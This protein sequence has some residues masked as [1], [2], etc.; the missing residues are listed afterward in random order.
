MAEDSFACSAAAQQWSKP[1]K[2][3]HFVAAQRHQ[4]RAAQN[5]SSS[6]RARGPPPC[7]GRNL[8]LGRDSPSPPGPNSVRRIL[9]IHHDPTAARRSRRS[10][11]PRRP[12]NPLTL[13]HLSPSLL[14]LHRSGGAGGGHVG[15]RL[16]RGKPQPEQIRP[17]PSRLPILFFTFSH[18]IS[19][20]AAPP[21][22]H[23]GG[24]RGRDMA[25]PGYPSPARA[26]DRSRARRRRV[27]LR[28]CP[29]T[30]AEVDPRRGEA[31][32]AGDSA[33]SHTLVGSDVL[34]TR[35][36]A[37]ARFPPDGGFCDGERSPR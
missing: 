33:S 11:S 10:K 30:E 2:P 35:R 29:S 5:A 15:R 13:A 21:G 1:A 7:P 31:T 6:A 18:R 12:L 26:C 23:A 36:L 9:A 3:A 16:R 25:P 19:Q 27:V 34:P 22:D 20:A 28:W 32:P 17:A 14:S 24:Q 4:L 37:A 8:G